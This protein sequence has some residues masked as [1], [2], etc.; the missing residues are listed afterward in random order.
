M[1]SMHFVTN[2]A[3]LPFQ[4]LQIIDEGELKEAETKAET[5]TKVLSGLRK[6]LSERINREGVD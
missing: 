5:L 1:S 6:S 3:E 4:Y 2:F